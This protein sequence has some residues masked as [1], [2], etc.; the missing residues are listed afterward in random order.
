[1]TEKYEN[2]KHNI[3]YKYNVQGS[4]WELLSRG[5]QYNN[6]CYNSNITEHRHNFGSQQ[7]FF[8]KKKKISV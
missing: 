3:I 7:V 5:V 1:M 4:N 8:V 2:C 6:L